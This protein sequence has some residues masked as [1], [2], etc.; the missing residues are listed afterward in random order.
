MQNVL[1]IK[2]D[3]L[4]KKK[5]IKNWI[6]FHDPF[7]E[8]LSIWRIKHETFEKNIKITVHNT[9]TILGKVEVGENTWFGPYKAL[10]GWKRGIKI[11]KNC[12]ISSCVNITDH[13]SVKWAFSG[14]MKKYEY[15]PV[16]IGHNCFVGTNAVITKRVSIENH[17]LVESNALVTKC[18]P[19]YSIIFWVPGRHMGNVIVTEEDL[20]LEYFD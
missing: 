13:Y 15:G 1:Q 6:I 12:S 2:Q 5:N 7:F 3:L 16:S 14:G 9:C 18:F 10:D 17:C 11:G 20:I 8:T 4:Y 19:D